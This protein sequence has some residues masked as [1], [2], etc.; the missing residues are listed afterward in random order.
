MDGDENRIQQ[1]LYNLVGNAIKFTERGEIIVSAERT[2]PWPPSR[3][4]F[5]HPLPLPGGEHPPLPLPGGEFKGDSP[6][7]G[8]QGGVLSISVSDT[9]IGIPQE[10]LE[11]IFT[12]FEQADTSIARE[13][14]GTGLGLPVTKAVGGTARR[15][16]WGGI[17]NRQGFNLY[18][19]AAS[20]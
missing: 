19:Y 4:E 20:S 5:T 2:P 1:I 11:D 17:R 9:G 16:D 12:S 13:Y 8:G 18:L 7:E 14:G 3:G 6:L 15:D 10:K